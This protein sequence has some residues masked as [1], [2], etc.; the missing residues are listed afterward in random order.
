MKITHIPG[1]VGLVAEVIDDFLKAARRFFRR[2]RKRSKPAPVIRDVL[3]LRPGR[4][5]PG[6]GRRFF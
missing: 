3:G 5:W 2:S 1:S 6:H 4:A